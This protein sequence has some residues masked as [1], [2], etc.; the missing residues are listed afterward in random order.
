MS[1]DVSQSTLRRFFST[2]A[3][4]HV[5]SDRARIQAMLD[6]EAALARAQAS[7]GIVPEAAAAAIAE[8][9]WTDQFDADELSEGMLKSGSLAIPLAKALTRVVAAT[10]EEAA[11]WV[12]WGATSQDIIDTGTVLQMREAMTLLDE[13]IDVVADRLAALAQAHIATPMVARS[14]MTHAVPTT[15]GLKI[16]GWLS[17]LT[18]S[19]LVLTGARPRILA[20]QFGGA[21]GNLAALAPHGMALSAALAEE[22]GLAE[23]E[24]PWHSQRD[25]IAEIGAILAILT[26]NLGKMGRDLALMAQTEVGEFREPSGD[27]RGGSSAMPHKA[28]PIGCGRMIAAAKR[29]PGLAAALLGGM[30]QEHER[31]LG[32]WHA[33]WEVLPD[34][35]HLAS[36]ALEAAGSLATEGHFD[37]DRMRLNL[38]MTGGLVMAEAVSI[39]LGRKLGKAAAHR[40]IEAASRQAVAEG[41][42]L[43]DCL[44]GASE[45]AAHFTEPDFAALFVAENHLGAASTFTNRAVDAWRSQKKTGAPM[46]N[47]LN[48]DAHG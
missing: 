37:V 43:K 33:E 16:A 45:I 35:F 26:G 14:L 22:L 2:E 8:A 24:L 28:N 17:A 18:R 9:A 19:K 40:L 13:Q 3:M 1:W 27:G 15:L 31:G 41:R 10:D 36:A 25:R 30:D 46:A 11:R 20:L 12:H 21:G 32:G 47:W 4:A 42:P 39:A 6:V 5:F 23:P 44:A 38:G 34:L 48:G 7:L 29:A